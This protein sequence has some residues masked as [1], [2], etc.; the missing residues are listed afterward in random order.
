L[1]IFGEGKEEEMV[2]TDKQIEEFVSRIKTPK[3]E[4]KKPEPEPA[5]VLGLESDRKLSVDGQRERVARD[6][7]ELVEAERE[8]PEESFFARRSREQR[9]AGLFYRRQY[10]ALAL[11][12]YWARQR[13]TPARR[14]EYNPVARFEGEMKDD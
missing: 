12:E 13:E 8:K 7:K 4:R 11:A 10:E 2:L 1:G 9:E 3:L 5:K 6:I 14:G